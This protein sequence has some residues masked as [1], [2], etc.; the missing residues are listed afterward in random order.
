M[1][2]KNYWRTT[3]YNVTLQPLKQIKILPEKLSKVLH[4]TVKKNFL[5]PVQTDLTVSTR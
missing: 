1:A 5:N 3:S 2:M 4:K